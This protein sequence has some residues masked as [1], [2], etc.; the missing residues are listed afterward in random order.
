MAVLKAKWLLKAT[1]IYQILLK[2]KGTNAIF[3]SDI[4]VVLDDLLLGGFLSYVECC[5]VTLQ[6]KGIKCSS[7]VS[8]GGSKVALHSSLFYGAAGCRW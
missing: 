2:A 6:Q 8:G 4:S 5:I 3:K 7:E 1:V